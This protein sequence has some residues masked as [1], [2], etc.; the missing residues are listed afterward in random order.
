MVLDILDGWFVT[1]GVHL[2]DTLI[3]IFRKARFFLL[4]P[5]TPILKVIT[6]HALSRLGVTIG[7]SPKADLCIL[8]KR[9]YARLWADQIFGL[10]EMFAEGWWTSGNLEVFYDKL[11]SL[12]DKHRW[13]FRLQISYWEG[14]FRWGVLNTGRDGTNFNAAREYELPV[15]FF[16]LL[17]DKEHMQ[18]SCGIYVNGA[19]TYADS[20]IE[21]F[22]LIASKLE[23]KP[24]MTLL[25]LGCGFGGLS[26]F[27][28]DNY[29]VTVT[30]VTVCES[31]ATQATNHCRGS[32][33]TIKTQ[34][35]RRM[36]GK[37][38]RISIIEMLEHVGKQNYDEFFTKI[39]SLLNPGG[40]ILLQH[41]VVDPGIPHFFE[42]ACKNHFGQTYV[43]ALN[44]FVTYSTRSFRIA[45]MQDFSL[46]LEQAGKHF[47]GMIEDNRP[48]MEALVGPKLVRALQITY[49]AALAATKFKGG[50][51]YQTVLVGKDDQNR[52]PVQ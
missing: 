25:D 20:Q 39:K 27:M 31:M 22:K 37:F 24:G 11:F 28:A 29:G 52:I 17:T 36:E 45:N 44:E 6:D 10:E 4:L 5:F 9:F 13:L 35:W 46:D 18:H 33:V 50:Q 19:T 21:K 15:E 14:L 26:K 7:S 48:E 1:V 30:G 23:L 8:D 3:P 12:G 40:R 16:K 34:H 47:M 2:Y 42:F 32:K 51:V 43:A 38:D 41:Y 49:A